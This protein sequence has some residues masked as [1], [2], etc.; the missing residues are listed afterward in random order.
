V[1]R[2][3]ALLAL[4][5]ASTWS[6]TSAVE[7]RRPPDEPPP[8]VDVP[9]GTIGVMSMHEVSVSIPAPPERVWSAVADVVNWPGWDPS[10][11][12]VEPLGDGPLA[13]GARFRVRQ[14]RLPVAV[15]TVSEL[16]P[17]RTFSW[18]S[19]S[20]GITSRG[21]HTVE[22]DGNG[23]RVLLRFAQSGPL[24]GLSGLVLGRL[25]RRYVQQEADGLRRHFEP[26]GSERA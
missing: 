23:S 21:D 7:G 20:L 26:A 19:S 6:A 18:T 4:W 13:V 9:L 5:D 2:R 15:W 17:G 12:A 11:T 10:V 1:G 22:P 25:I 16:E 8:R 3:S 24:A 14:P